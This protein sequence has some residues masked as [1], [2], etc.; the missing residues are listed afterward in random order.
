MEPPPTIHFESDLEMIK[1]YGPYT[2]RE[3]YRFFCFYDTETKKST[4]V[5]EHRLKM[6]KKLGRKLSRSELVHHKNERT[7]DNKNKNLQ[8]MSYSQHNKHHATGVGKVLIECI[9]CG[10]KFYREMANIRRAIKKH[11][12]GPFCGKS[13]VG[14]ASRREQLLRQRGQFR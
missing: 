4:S 6:E 13:C 8:V 2:N 14:L 9:E 7:G 1:K 5:F 12:A 11:L 3:G 10:T